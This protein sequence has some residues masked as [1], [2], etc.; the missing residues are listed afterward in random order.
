MV[1]NQEL[2]CCGL[3][4]FFF[5]PWVPDQE[6]FYCGLVPFSLTGGYQTENYTIMVWYPSFFAHRY[7][8][9]NYYDHHFTPLMD[10]AITFWD[11]MILNM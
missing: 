11:I 7:Q 1:P 2:Y 4:P 6:L 8:I 10:R 5:C 3:A 9:K